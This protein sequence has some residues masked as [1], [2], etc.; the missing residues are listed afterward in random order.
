VAGNGLSGFSGDG[1]P[2]T[3]ATFYVL[4][5]IAIDSIGNLYIT[6]AGNYRI[7]KIDVSGII[8]TVAGNGTSGYSGDG[9]PATQAML[10]PSDASVD[11]TGNLY[12]ADYANS[13]IRKVDP[14]GVITTIAG[15]GTY[16]YTGDGGPATEAGFYM[17]RS[18]AV[19]AL[20]NLYIADTNNNRIR[21]I[22]L[23]KVL[24]LDM[25]P[26]DIAFAEENGLGYLFNSAGRHKKTIDLDT[27]ITLYTF[28][29][30]QNGNL[31]SITDQFGNN[32]TI[33]RDTNGVPTAIIS[34]D[35]ITT[36]LAIDT[37][38]YLTRISYPDGNFYN[39]EYMTGGL[40]TAKI[41]LEGNRFEHLFDSTGR[42][43]DALDQEGGHWN[44]SRQVYEN[45]DILAEILSA[46]GNLTSYLDHTEST[47]AYTSRITDPTGAQT[48]FTLSA[49]G[50]T[51]SKSLPCGMNLS[52][53]YEI[54][55]QYKF[56]YVKEMREK[57]P[58][59]LEKVIFREKMYED[60]NADNAIDR[61][62]NRLTLNGKLTTLM[63]D[64]LQSKKTLNSPVGR[65]TTTFYDPNNLLTT[66]LTIP[67]LYDTTYGYDSKGRL[68]SVNTNNRQ[69][70]FGYDT[71]GNLFSITDPENKTTTYSYDAVGRMTGIHR[72][73]SSSVSFTY[74]KNANMTVLTNPSTVNHG[75]G[76]N[77]VNLNSSYQTPLSGRYSYLYNRDRRLLQIN[78][79]SGKQIRNIYDKDRVIQTQTPEEN[80]DISYLCGSKVGLITKGTE[81]ISYGYDGS[82]VTSETLSG[83]LNQTLSYTY[84]NDFNLS[85]LTYAGSPVNYTYDNDGLLIGAGGFTIARNAGNGLPE[86]VTG[87]ALNLT[88]TF[89]GYGE[90]ESQ[91]FSVNA[92]SLTSWGVTQDNAGRI[93]SKSEMVEGI[94]SNYVYTYDSMGR[95]LTV[96]I[97]G[98]LIEEYQ[99]DSVGRR[100]YEMNVQKGI[101]GRAYTY[102]DEDH[103]LTAGGVTYQY[104]AD[105]FLTTKT[106]GSDI[107]HY[108][109]SSRGELLNVNLPDSTVIE[110]INDPLGRRI[111]KKVN[112]LVVEKYLWQGLTRLLAVYD[113]SN[114]LVMRFEYADARMPVA[115][116]KGGITYYLTY[117]Q[118]GSLRAVA[119]A[120]GN[121][122]KR[123]DY[124]SFGNIIDDTNTGFTIPFGFAGG[125][126]DRDT[127]LVRFGF[128]DYDPDTGRWTAKDPILF[129]AGQVDLYGYVANNPV[130]MI[131]PA[132]E[133]VL[134]GGLGAGGFFGWKKGWLSQVSIGLAFDTTTKEFVVYKSSAA[135]EPPF[136]TVI[137]LGLGAGPFG[138]ILEG[139]MNDFLGR[140]WEETGYLIGS[141]T[142]ITTCSGK[143]GASGSV[144]GKGFAIGYTDVMSNTTVLYRFNAK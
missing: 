61:I 83:T 38:N 18:M 93:I 23:R 110:Y 95:L 9:G 26:G 36:T 68:T 33:Q 101:S 124:D 117:D 73:D 59:N 86:S 40:M 106:R 71:Q 27:G 118:V 120:S 41:E 82:L 32:T 47:G 48:V 30:D 98:A 42:L 89:N 132:G 37:N 119:D 81:G 79:P 137:G 111:A 55:P 109:Y 49:D 121:T 100:T 34:P 60:T 139:N 136:G 46:E 138:G 122:I 108:S 123:I 7:R 29:Y 15:N 127:G 75:F 94:T 21:K 97:D 88:R 92:S 52:F 19:D 112:G 104:D 129:I 141:V 14:S 35:G 87:G 39:F 58:S 135:T 105:G 56:Q 67:G 103:L 66:R 3:Q 43:T 2:A 78:F 1:G 143:R 65:T 116:T 64:T 114:N 130:N 128:R 57:T 16:S 62:T 70:T 24:N 10:I 126:Y 85:G 91:N 74:D 90:L 31:V 4:V 80:I 17:P 51:G 84:N 22:D 115:M 5:G 13:R 20:G 76:Y 77:K 102:S 54:D 72:P 140:S 133:R 142:S 131:D 6:D 69:A 134:F 53:K 99:Y 63:T 11:T 45:G 96:T 50:L 107:T 8:T 113:G 125:L 28:N 12:I 25:A 144:G 44:F